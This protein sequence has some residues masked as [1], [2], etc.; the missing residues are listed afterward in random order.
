M[1]FLF[2]AILLSVCAAAAVCP[3]RRPRW[4]ATR[5]YVV[6]MTVNEMP[7]I[8]IGLGVVSLSVSTDQ[9]GPGNPVSLIAGALT[10][11]A[12]G[13]LISA[14]VVTLRFRTAPISAVDAALP[15]C[16]GAS[17]GLTRA[18]LMRGVLFPF[19]PRRSGLARV[20]HHRYG[21]DRRHRL[22][23]F[24]GQ[25]AGPAAPILIHFHGG[26]VRTGD[27]GR[28]S[29]HLLTSLARHGWVCV[30]AT[31]RLREAGAFPASVV[32][33]KRALAWIRGH[34]H[35][36]GV[37]P[38]RVVAAGNSAGAH[39][40]MFLA[41]SPGDPSF[42]PGFESADTSVSAAVGLYGYYGPR[43]SD[44]ASSPAQHATPATPPI[45]VL[46]GDRDSIVPVAWA[47]RFAQRLQRVSQH[48][49]I[50]AELHGAQHTFDMFSSVRAQAV[51]IA[52][53][54]FGRWAVG[55]DGVLA[56]RLG[57]ATDG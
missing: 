20:E 56:K 8:W 37:D 52:I 32:D 12:I 4:L 10:A 9:I 34:A 51:A 2:S 36:L 22:Q 5:M 49:V 11:T 3:V 23:V 28:E 31:Y 1:G 54:R 21:P 35:S 27:A 43:S 16:S 14:L 6:G 15:G 40:A 24:R 26:R 39:L 48:P 57:S 38:T 25:D 53:E 18:Q 44:A 33:A 42:Q 19:L 46:H 30:S 17:P 7:I 41:L 45:L 13:A 29:L 47:R 50:Y 55:I